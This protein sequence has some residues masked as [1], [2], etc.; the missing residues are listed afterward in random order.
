M[1]FTLATAAA[2]AANEQNIDALI[3]SL[4]NMQAAQASLESWGYTD[5]W[6]RAFDPEGI[7]VAMTGVEPSV[8]GFAEGVKNTIAKIIEWIKVTI[9]KIKDFFTGDNARLRSVE[10]MTAELIKENP[11]LAK[12][13]HG[14]TADLQKVAVFTKSVKKEKVQLI[15]LDA[16]VKY[17]DFLMT[18]FA[19]NAG[20]PTPDTVSLMKE[21]KTKAETLE[22]GMLVDVW[23][24][25]DSPV[26]WS[27][28]NFDKLV[29]RVPA[30]HGVLTA[31]LDEA[32][33]GLEK[34][35]AM[36][37]ESTNYKG[38]GTRRVYIEYY[39][40][41]I[42]AANIC[43]GLVEQLIASL[44]RVDKRFVSEIRMYNQHHKK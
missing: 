19:R 34:T 11:D 13:L 33:K 7:L 8:E 14:G 15:S 20:E 3:A 26:N 22:K 9:R 16:A 29:S 23:S 24:V 28:E 31:Y 41:G 27:P 43:L 17:V 35:R 5:R 6:K 25:F 44:S 36:D 37:L 2:P 1:K 30:V 40:A 42:T 39:S 38:T 12:M 4:E 10:Q 18:S 32:E 21:F